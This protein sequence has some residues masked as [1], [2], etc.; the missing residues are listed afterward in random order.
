[1]AAYVSTNMNL[2]LCNPN[3]W[4]S[5]PQKLLVKSRKILQRRYTYLYTK[6][7]KSILEEIFRQYLGFFEISS[8][9]ISKKQ[10]SVQVGANPTAISF[11]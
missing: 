4:S 3:V 10:V 1:M 5:F 9:W 8:V 7:E 2:W 6:N 11:L